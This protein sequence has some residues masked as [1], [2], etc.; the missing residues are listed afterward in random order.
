MVIGNNDDAAI[1]AMQFLNF[2]NHLT[3][4]TNQSKKTICLSQKWKNNLAEAGITIFEGQIQE[5]IGESGMMNKVI[6]D[7]GVKIDTDFM[8]NQQGAI[9]NS[10]LALDLGVKLDEHGYII[11]DF[12]QRTNISCVFAAG[13][14][15]KPFAHQIVTAAHE[16]SSAAESANY[17]LYNK[18]QKYK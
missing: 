18:N 1:T 9:P 14:V 13:D 10:K 2:T 4:V 8:F 5:V 16:G 15:T 7:S 11:T 3:F 6:L 17:E 12:E